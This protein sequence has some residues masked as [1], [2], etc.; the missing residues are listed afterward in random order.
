MF[1]GYGGIIW[2]G[3]LVTIQLSLLSMLVAFVLG[4]IAAIAKLF[5]SKILVWFADIYTTIIR[6]IPDLVLMLVIFFGLQ[7]GL[8]HVTEYF[9]MAQINID[10]FSAGVITIGFIYGA[11]FT[12]TFRGAFLT[13]SKG[14]IEAGTAYGFTPRQVFQKII[15]PQMMRFALP[16][17]SNNWLITMKATALVSIIGLQDVVK[18]SQDAGKGTYQFFYFTVI[19]GAIYLAFTTLSNIVFWWLGRVYSTGKKKAEL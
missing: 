15:F 9:G 6:G 2:Q 14:Q 11:Y 4:L 12:E 5:G 1:Y 16:G 8:N 17:L 7:I 18:V 19:A 3:T 13:V 10:P